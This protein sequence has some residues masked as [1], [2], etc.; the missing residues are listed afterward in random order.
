MHQARVSCG[1]G[2]RGKCWARESIKIV[3]KQQQVCNENRYMYPSL[4]T[5]VLNILTDRRARGFCNGCRTVTCTAIYQCYLAKGLNKCLQNM[6]IDTWY[7][8]SDSR[9]VEVKLFSHPRSAILL[10]NGKPTSIRRPD[11]QV[12]TIGRLAAETMEWTLPSNSK[13]CKKKGTKGKTR[14]YQIVP[15]LP[16]M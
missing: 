15:F 9:A 14:F 6:P 4:C 2:I 11:T 1:H 10:H 7:A 16:G 12:R 8:S 3:N 5:H 13:V